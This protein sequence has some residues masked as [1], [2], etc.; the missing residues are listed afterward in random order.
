VAA[1][2]DIIGAQ[3]DFGASKRGVSMGPMAIRYGGLCEGLRQLGFT[4]N[5]LGDIVPIPAGATLENMRNY[6]QVVDV[7]RKLYQ[8]VSDTLTSGHFPI[9]LGG[10]HSI[11]AGSIS[12][13]VHHNRNLGVIW[14]DAHGDWNNEESTPTGNMHGMPFSAV[15]GYG[16]DCMVNLGDKPVFVDIRHCVQ[17]GGRD[18]DTAERQRMKKAGVTVFPINAIDKLGMERVIAQAIE[19]AGAGGANIHLSFDIDAIDPQAAPGTG[20][21]VHSGL[22]V[23]E[24]FLAVESIAD[25]GKLC[26]MDMVE[27]NPILDERNKTGI[28]ASELIQSALGKAVY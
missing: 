24:A 26:S 19:I 22:T 16:P 10:D 20:T 1:I 21:V 27:V 25:S 13:A 14:I 12:A 28:L 23:R 9:I 5:D 18:I 11:A 15:C 17:I 8:I 2:L 6:E 4:V 3:M 7:N